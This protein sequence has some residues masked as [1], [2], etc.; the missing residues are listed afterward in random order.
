MTKEAVLPTIDGPSHPYVTVSCRDTMSAL[1]AKLKDAVSPTRPED[2]LEYR[3]WRIEPAGDDFNHPEFPA[4]EL[5]TS[6]PKLLDPDDTPVEDKSI[7]SNDAFVVE[8]RGAT[9]WL[10]D[11]VTFALTSKLSIAA[12]KPLF[13][14]SESFFNRME[15][16]SNAYKATTRNIFSSGSNKPNNL[17]NSAR[18]SQRPVEPGTIGLV[19]L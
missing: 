18:T 15:T 5:A 14:S 4:S 17:F 9:G 19:N 10:V 2:P 16:P 6:E 13:P 12:P 8:F 11:A 1:C 3:V 7:I